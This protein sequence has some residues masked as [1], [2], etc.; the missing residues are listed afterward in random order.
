MFA[1]SVITP[2]EDQEHTFFIVP[3]AEEERFVATGTEPGLY[4]SARLDLMLEILNGYQEYLHQH[5][6]SFETEHYH[7]SKTQ[8][9]K[10]MLAR[11]T[12]RES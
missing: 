2:V 5:A 4:T 1:Y 8:L 6:D 11:V 9:D 7:Y 3:L 12:A 10:G